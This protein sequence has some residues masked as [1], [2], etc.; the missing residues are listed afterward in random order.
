M[1]RVETA[2]WEQRVAN[3]SQEGLLS[4]LGKYVNESGRSGQGKAPSLVHPG[5]CVGGKKER[6]SVCN[7]ANVILPDVIAFW[8][9]VEAVDTEGFGFAWGGW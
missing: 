8:I 9:P 4:C 2:W 1:T 7:P 3:A 5:W 6:L